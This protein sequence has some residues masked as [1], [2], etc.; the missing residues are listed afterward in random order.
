[1]TFPSQRRPNFVGHS[2]CSHTWS[3]LSA[4]LGGLLMF[5][6]PFSLQKSRRRDSNSHSGR[7]L[8]IE[9]RLG[10]PLCLST[11]AYVKSVLGLTLHLTS[12]YSFPAKVVENQGVLF[13]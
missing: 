2:D 1:M 11:A 13:R 7:I 8:P 12:P 9:V 5:H 3:H 10:L 6:S 4:S